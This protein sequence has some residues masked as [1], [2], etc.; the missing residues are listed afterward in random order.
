M[1]KTLL[2]LEICFFCHIRIKQDIISGSNIIEIP[3][4]IA[5]RMIYLT[6]LMLRVSVAS[7]VRST[8]QASVGVKLT[9]DK[10]YFFISSSSITSST[11]DYLVGFYL[12]AD[13]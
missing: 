3:P 10:R 7:G 4:A 5:K 1:T 9:D 13:I 6:N 11:T 2:L 12:L 8:T